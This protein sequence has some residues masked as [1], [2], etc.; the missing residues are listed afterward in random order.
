MKNRLYH[1]RAE[2]ALIVLLAIAKSFVSKITTFQTFRPSWTLE[3]AEGL[4]SR[5]ENAI[6]RYWVLM[7]KFSKKRLP[8]VFLN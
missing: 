4:A 1:C 7:L 2:Q 6:K 8:E 3:Y 5:I